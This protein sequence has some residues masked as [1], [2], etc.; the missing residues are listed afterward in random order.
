VAFFILNIMISTF[1]LKLF[2]LFLFILHSPFSILNSFAQQPGG[3]RSGGGEMPDLGALGAVV[4]MIVDENKTPVQYATVFVQ[5]ATDSTTV[6]GGVSDE[7]GRIIIKEIP[8]G[9][10]YLQVNAMGYHK[11]FTPTFTLTQS[12][13]RYM[14]NRFAV[15][16]KP[17]QLQGVEVTTQK[18]MLQQNLDKKVY[19]LEN[20][21]V[22][23]GATA[24]QALAEIPSVDVDI[25]G[26]VSLRGTG[27]VTILVD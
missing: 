19:N 24:V 15:T 4:G 27:N 13:P 2:C 1:R 10:Y 6:T 12:N 16:Q 17:Q 21:I 26:N 25:E 8:W 5:H 11:H 9:S 23:E 3:G 18:E 20:S 14:M 22:T 7:N